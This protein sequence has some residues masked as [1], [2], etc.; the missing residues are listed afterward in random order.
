MKIFLPNSAFLW[1]IES[2]LSKFDPENPK[3]LIV[4]SHE[5]WVAVHPMVLSMTAALALAVKKVNGV[6]RVKD[7]LAKSKPYLIRMGL[8]KFLDHEVGTA[9]VEHDASGRFIPITQIS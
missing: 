4:E 1:N 8:L 7:P 9:I 5:K 2:Y 6:I 3:E